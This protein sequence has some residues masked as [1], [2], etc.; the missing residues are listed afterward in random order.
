MIRAEHLR[1]VFWPPRSQPVEAVK[2]A[3]FSVA[4]GEVL[5]LLGPNGAGKTTLLRML[6]TI[7]VPTAGHCW[8]GDIRADEAQDEIRR[9]I[10][11]L[12]GNT[13]LYGRLTARETLYYFGRLYGMAD[14][15]IAQRIDEIGAL[16][17]MQEF[18]ERRCESLSTGQTQKVSI[19]RVILHD[20]EV[21]IL[22]EPTLGLDIMTSQAI[23]D[24]I[25]DARTRQHS[26]IFSTH[27][28][29]DAELLCDRVALMH[30]G[31]IMDIGAKSELYARS[32]TDNLHDAFLRMVEER[33]QATA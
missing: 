16:L 18:L 8:I 10:G 17:H 22:D 14:P 27:Y 23:L 30:R 2:D 13:K 33:E 20:P 7:I 6:G 5:G 4:D 12:S 28:M 24:F 3:S 29:S 9:H 25:I 15:L 32:G 21:L 11:F 1:K 19:A 26:I 31:E